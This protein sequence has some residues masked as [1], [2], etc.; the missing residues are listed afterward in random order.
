MSENE[1]YALRPIPKEERT[2]ITAPLFNLLGC[3]I[4]ISELMVGGTLITG[5]SFKNML[6][7]S[8]IGNLILVLILVVQ[9]NIGCREGLNTYVLADGVFGEKAGKWIIS[10][11]LGI[12]SFGWFGIQAGV[13]GLSVQKILPNVNLTI[14]IIILG[15]L[16][17]VI[18]VIGFKAMAIFNY[19][20]IPPLI[21]L[22]IWGLIKVFSGGSNLSVSSYVPKNPISLVD[23]INIV[24][25]LVIVGVIISPDYLRYSRRLKDIFVIGLVSF[26]GISI[27][28]QVAA[29]LLSMQAPSWDI[30]KV[31]SDLGF[32]WVAFVILILAAWSTNLSNAYSGGLALKTIFPNSDRKKLTAIAGIIGTLIAASGIIFK[33]QQFLSILS[34]TIPSIGGIMWTEYY[35]VNKRKFVMRKDTN[36]CALIAW[37][38]GFAISYFS[39]KF[40]FGLP[41]INGIVFSGIV[42]LI[43]ENTFD[44]KNINERKVE[45][46]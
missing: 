21:L 38:I 45:K 22:M 42:Y 3:N 43:L 37:V 32:N 17:M 20:A 26:A 46:A 6:I 4:A 5:L 33:F 7:A 30:T 12:S 18:A 19:V 34:L 15:I 36:W 39:N 11:I 35:I 40:K 25:G 28:Q 16:M 29:A 14:T 1:N 13:A 24:V 10:L 41:P 8:I 44:K 27:F 2:G 23:G 9:G 31:L